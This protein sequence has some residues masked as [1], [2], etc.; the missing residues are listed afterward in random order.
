MDLE[1][2]PE[3]DRQN[4]RAGSKKIISPRG[5]LLTISA[6]E[7]VEYGFALKAVTSREALY[8]TLEVSGSWSRVT[9]HGP[10][11]GAGRLSERS[12]SKRVDA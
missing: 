11:D 3:A 6:R 8:D 5:Q 12:R 10:L 2:M 4:I 7:A 1:L 9:V